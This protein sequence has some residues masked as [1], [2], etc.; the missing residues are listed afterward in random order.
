MFGLLVS[1]VALSALQVRAQTYT[2]TYLPWNAPDHTE[3][4]QQGTNA[5][6]N[7]SSQDSECQ[8]LYSEPRDLRSTLDDNLSPHSTV[9]SVEDFCLFAPPVA[10]ANSAIGN[11][12]VC[13]SYN[14]S[15]FGL[16][17]VSTSKS[18]SLGA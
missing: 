16:F 18:K 14:L 4:G 10:G 1:A 2:A 15:F 5:C 3:Q 7:G 6:G 12:E 17:I 13:G 8:N 9:N 11:T